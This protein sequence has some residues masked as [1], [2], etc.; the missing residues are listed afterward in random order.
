MNF[1]KKF[2]N[3][4]ESELQSVV[5]TLNGQ[6]KAI[7]SNVIQ[8]IPRLYYFPFPKSNEIVNKFFLNIFNFFFYLF[9]S[10]KNKKK[11]YI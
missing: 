3:K 11:H 5:T 10:A 9:N 6:K 8:I 1:L 4:L 7:R 2:R